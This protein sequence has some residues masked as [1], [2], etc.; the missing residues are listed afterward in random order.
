MDS[1]DKWHIALTSASVVIPWFL[2]SI[3]IQWKISIV[4]LAL[5]VSCAFYCRRL[6]KEIAGLRETCDQ[7][8][9]KHKALAKRYDKRRTDILRYEAC[10]FSIERLIISTMQ[11]TRQDRLM[12]LYES[13]LKI[14]AELIPEDKEGV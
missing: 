7:L 2:P 13:F 10:F 9:G 3:S 8:S 12:I 5:L 14:K 4:L 1:F 6:C 11:T